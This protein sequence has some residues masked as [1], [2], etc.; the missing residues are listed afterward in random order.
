MSIKVQCILLLATLS[1]G[2]LCALPTEATVQAKNELEAAIIET[3]TRIVRQKHKVETLEIEL[4]KEK[5]LLNQ[6]E[7]AQATQ[8]KELSAW[9]NNTASHS[10]TRIEV[11]QV[12]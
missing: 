8:T 11:P 7:E 1:N 12:N 3:S 5:D 4:K 9:N 2:L 10:R 6:L